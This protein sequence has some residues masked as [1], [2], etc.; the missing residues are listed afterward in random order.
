MDFE[1][2]NSRSGARWEINYSKT[3]V[4]A[5][6]SL[7]EDSSLSRNLILFQEL[8]M[9]TSEPKFWFIFISDFLIIF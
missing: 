9:R 6:M 2:Q 5:T 4:W 8:S 3:T 1:I 7:P